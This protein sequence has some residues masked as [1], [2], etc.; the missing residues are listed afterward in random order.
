MPSFDASSVIS[1]V[2]SR[3]R[4]MNSIRNIGNSFCKVSIPGIGTATKLSSGD[5]HVD[6][7]DGSTL[8]VSIFINYINNIRISKMR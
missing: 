1:T 2:A 6:Y 7:R 4:K 8:T 3:S 5:I